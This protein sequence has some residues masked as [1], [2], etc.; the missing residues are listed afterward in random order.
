MGPGRHGLR[1]WTNPE[2][3]L[4]KILDQRYKGE[5]N[6]N[7]LLLPYFSGKSAEQYSTKRMALREEAESSDGSN[8]SISSEQD[9]EVARAVNMVDHVEQATDTN[10]PEE[11]W[12]APFE[13]YILNTRANCEGPLAEIGKSI[14]NS[15]LQ[16]RDNN[17]VLEK[18]LDKAINELT[19]AITGI[20]APKDNNAKGRDTSGVV[21]R[22][23][24]QP[25]HNQRK[26]TRFARCQELFDKC[27]KKLAEAAISGD[28]SIITKKKEP[29]HKDTI[30][31]FYTAL[32][33]SEGPEQ[34][35]DPAPKPTEMR[36]AFQ[37][38]T[39]DEVK[40]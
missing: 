6:I 40:S 8:E 1:V 9:T 16:L 23:I 17:N 5:R 33:G 15:W 4:L 25:N 38:I 37:P 11:D 39:A 10:G 24:R 19:G 22:R 30:A 20:S 27:P 36:L 34:K 7:Q 13:K 26:K 35:R 14:A 18:S 29:P 21:R 3:E 2:I 32:W 28:L 12:H 31:Q